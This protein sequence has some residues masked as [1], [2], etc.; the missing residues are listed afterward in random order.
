M[1]TALT[2]VVIL[3]V[4]GNVGSIAPQTESKSYAE[5][6]KLLLAMD[7]SSSNKPFVELF[8]EADV[9]QSDLVQ[10]LYDPEERVSLNA[11]SIILYLADAEGL[12]A[13]QKWFQYRRA[14]SDKYLESPVKLLDEATFL[15]GQDADLGELV[16]KNLY[17]NEK[18][19]RAKVIAY[20][21]HTDTAIVE[22]V[23]LPLPEVF[24]S[25]W[26]VTIRRENGRWR[27]LSKYGVWEH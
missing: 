27:I 17:P 10:A 16:L 20:N 13:L 1:R 18:G 23:D 2:L 3:L 6:R 8:E 11:Q 14:H 22:V 7:R 4:A 19:F 26:H 24:N 12:A 5:T 21:K 9:R 25:G 15:T